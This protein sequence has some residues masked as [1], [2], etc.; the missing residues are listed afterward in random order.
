VSLAQR[1]LFGAVLIVTVL[2]VVAVALSG[3]RLETQLQQLI[4]AQLAD[5]ARFIAQQWRGAENPDE[6]AD[7]AGA[8][9]NHRV[10]LVDSSG[11]VLGDSEFS[12]PALAVL[13]NHNTRPE[14]VAARR[15]GLGASTRISPSEGDEELYVAV[16]AG[17]G[18]IARVS[19][20]T[21]RVRTITARAQ[22]D[23]VVS[24]LVALLIAIAL[25]AIF[26]RQV[27]RPVAELRDV[28]GA[29]A[30]GDLSRRPSLSAP[31]EVGELPRRFTEWASSSARGCRRSRRR[32]SSSARSW[33]R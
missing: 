22:R 4:E 15:T 23:L 19:I 13:Q 24:G 18:R 16:P 27:S 10:T 32:T 31:G 17:E 5:E 29:I 30:A 11:A 21:M 7:S 28:A 6:L 26:S 1:L 9:L 25:A 33:S 8:A 12:G 14:I 2:I 3:Q 20:G